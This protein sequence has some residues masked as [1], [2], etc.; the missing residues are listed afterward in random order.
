MLVLILDSLGAG[1]AE[2][3][4]DAVGFLGNVEVWKRSDLKHLTMKN[5][6]ETGNISHYEASSLARLR[7]TAA[8]AAQNLK[9]SNHQHISRFNLST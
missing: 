4:E 9:Y 1:A 5:S 2:D 3:D 6:G 8:S 7:D